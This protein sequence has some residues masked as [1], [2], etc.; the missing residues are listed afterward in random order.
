[1]VVVGTLTGVLKSTITCPQCTSPWRKFDVFNTL[2]GP[3]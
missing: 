1:M 2:Q 3:L